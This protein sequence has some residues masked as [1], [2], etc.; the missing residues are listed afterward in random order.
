MRIIFTLFIAISLTSCGQTDIDPIADVASFGHGNFISVSLIM[1]SQVESV[2]VKTGASGLN[3]EINQINRGI[4]TTTVEI[5]DNVLH[6]GNDSI[7][8]FEDTENLLLTGIGKVEDTVICQFQK[9]DVKELQQQHFPQGRVAAE[10][11]TTPNGDRMKF[12]SFRSDNRL[13]LV[14]S[15]EPKDIDFQQISD[16]P[17]EHFDFT[18]N[19]FNVEFNTGT[20]IIKHSFPLGKVVN[21]NEEVENNGI[22]LLIGSRIV[23]GNIFHIASV[24]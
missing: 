7:K 11:I 21:A 13:S 16:V 6:A 18:D 3:I 20:R 15:V 5:V 10:N 19:M 1:Q 9:T 12:R 2:N 8:L 24:N 4:E 17:I 23:M 22:G 14:L